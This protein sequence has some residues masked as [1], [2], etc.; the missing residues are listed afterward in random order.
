MSPCM[1][2]Q[3]CRHA[4]RVLKSIIGP[5]GRGDRGGRGCS[6]GGMGRHHRADGFALSASL[7]RQPYLSLTTSRECFRPLIRAVPCSCNTTCALCLTD[8]REQRTHMSPI[9]FGVVCTGKLCVV[10]GLPT[11]TCAYWKAILAC[12]AARCEHFCP[13]ALSY[14]YFLRCYTTYPVHSCG[15]CTEHL[16]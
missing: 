2:I 15:A 7:T 14:S 6:E 13:P 3:P 1:A 16:P 10:F 8:R 12:T 9:R 5:R 11:I 4:A